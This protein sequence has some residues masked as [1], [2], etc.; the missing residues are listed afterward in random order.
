MKRINEDIKSGNLKQ[1]YLLCGEEDY[2]RNQYRNRLKDALLNGGDTM[3]LSIYEGKDI[4]QAQII[5]K[6]EEVPFFADRRVIIIENSGLFKNSGAD[7]LAE[8]IGECFETTYFVFNEKEVDKRNKLYKAVREHG[9]IGEFHEQ[10]ETTLSRWVAGLAKKE[11]LEMDA[12]AIST[13]LYKT[14][15]DMENIHSELEKCICYCLNKG[16]ITAADVETI[17]TER[18]ANRIF[19]MINYLA[20]GRQEK[21]LH[22]YY[23]LLSLKEPPM[24]ILALLARQFNLLLQARSLRE[25]GYDRR[26]IAQKMGVPPFVAGKCLDQ[27]SRFKKETL[28]AAIDDCVRADEDIKTG[29]VP[30]VMS[31]ELFMMKYGNVAG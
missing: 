26:T 5:D 17:C 20:T 27:A 11:N 1:I 6:A 21:A 31:V 24:R 28:R 19:D 8:Y 15:T 4:N 25:Q 13:L 9:Y 18:I 7:Q 2:L 10:D 16:K 29:K 22:L 23:D 3:N 14:G 12:M 30:D